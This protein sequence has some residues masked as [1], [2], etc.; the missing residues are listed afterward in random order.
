MAYFEDLSDYI[1]CS[2]PC[3]H[4]TKNVG[5]LEHGHSFEEMIPTEKVLNLLLAHCTISVEQTRGIHECDLCV[6]PNTVFAGRKGQRV[7]LGTSEM[8]VF[9]RTGQ[10]YAAPTLVYHYVHIHRYRPPE[11]F[12]RALGEGPIPPGQEYFEQL[13]NAGLEWGK[14]SSPP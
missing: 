11:E 12:L 1:Y 2:D 14:T 6:P 13:K 8:R 4:G 3:H 9:S 7:L 10:I 5:W